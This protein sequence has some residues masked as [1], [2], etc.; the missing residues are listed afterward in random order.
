MA[1]Q[2]N[3]HTNS[4]SSDYKGEIESFNGQS[5][6]I[7]PENSAMAI[8]KYKGESYIPGVYGSSNYNS[9]NV[10]ATNADML[11]DQ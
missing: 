3:S 5:S 2:I 10:Q 9:A 11:A 1:D 6:I 8:N 7:G 4:I